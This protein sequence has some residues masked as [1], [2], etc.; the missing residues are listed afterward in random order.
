MSALIRLILWLCV[1]FIAWLM[2]AG[3]G[4]AQRR[5][6][7]PFA[8]IPVRYHGRL[9]PMDRFALLI[10]EDISGHTKIIS[11]PRS[12]PMA[13]LELAKQLIHEP[14]SL[15]D[16]PLIPIGNAKLK[17]KLSL[18]TGTEYFSANELVQCEQLFVIAS[19]QQAKSVEHP[20]YSP[21]KIERE[22]MEIHRR[23]S[24]LD[25]LC[26]GKGFVIHD[27]D[28][29]DLAGFELFSSTHNPWRVVLYISTIGLLF[30]GLRFMRSGRWVKILMLLTVVATIGVFGLGMWLRMMYL[31]RVPAGNTFEALLWIG[32]GSLVFACIGFLRS[33]KAWLLGCGLVGIAVATAFA[34]LVPMNQREAPLAMSLA[35]NLWLFFHVITITVSF[36]ALLLGAALGHVYLIHRR[37][38]SGAEES[39]RIAMAIYRSLQIGSILLVAGIILGGVWANTS[40]GRFWGWDPKETWS[41]ITFLIYVVFLHARK[42]G[43]VGDVGLAICSIF[44]LAAISWT[45]YGLNYLVGSGL[46]TYGFGNGSPGWLAGWLIGEIVFVHYCMSTSPI[47]RH[48][49]DQG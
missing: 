40:W 33:Q 16:E 30:M 3:L 37:F 32:I 27:S 24:L 28:D 14:R 13:P 25:G 22:V 15:L 45:F 26:S 2:I 42:A 29:Y 12:Y 18:Q 11:S 31:D 36:G 17:A 9:M 21:T 10:S 48:P 38:A 1:L 5:L 49:S 46:H 43:W 47:H 35:N 8:A 44:G 6:G 20:R 39:H 7:D 4:D 19:M 41:L 34:L 23:I